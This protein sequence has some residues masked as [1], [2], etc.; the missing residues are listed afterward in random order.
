MNIQSFLKLVEIQT[1]VAS[2]IPFMIGTSY[3]IFKFD[4]FNIK[5]AFLMFLAMIFFDMT[6]T[7]INNYMDYKKAIKKDGYGYETHNAVVS[8]NI[9]PK[10]VRVTIYIM[11]VIAAVLG[12]VLVENT[13]IVVL[14]LGMVSF[15][16]GILYSFGPIPIS[17]TPFGEILSGLTMGFIITFISVYIHIFDF[18]IIKITLSLSSNLLGLSLNIN[19]LV[20]IFIVSIP[21]IVGISNIML[22][23][24][25]C[26]IE[27]DIENKRYTLPIYIGK[28]NALKIFKALYYIGFISIIVGVVFRILPWISLVTLIALKP[29]NNNINEFMKLQTKKDTFIL[30]VKNFVAMN[31]IYIVTIIVGIF[32][33]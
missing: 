3:A 29:I 27:E 5:N 23:N 22:A 7:A 30:A 4:N 28:E 17:R 13:D 9:N 1:K 2:V 14:A 26:D 11:L 21:A 19:E 8:Y 25:I 12:I 32:L 18:N 24:N 33:E 6:T 16:I 15:T 20:A 31:G 10:T